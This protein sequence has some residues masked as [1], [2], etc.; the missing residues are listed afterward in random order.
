MKKLLLLL[1]AIVPLVAQTSDSN[2]RSLS[3]VTFAN[4]GTPANGTIVYCSD[5]TAA[6]PVAGSGTGVMARRENGVWNGGAANA[7]SGA[8][9]LVESHTASTS[10]ELDFTTCISGTYDTY[11]IE[12]LN[13]LAVT[14]AANITLQASTNGGASYDTGTNYSTDELIWRFNGATEV[15][16]TGLTAILIN[17]TNGTQNN[18]STWGVAGYMELFNPGSTTVFKEFVGQVGWLDATGRIAASFRSAYESA[19]A[20]NAFR[21]IAS[22]GNLASGTVRCYGLTH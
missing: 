21:I 1:A 17:G 19:T 18:T 3:V 14:S 22:S 4:L 16:G 6:N 11:K 20:M 2:P 10:A 7:G 13:V 12:F 9:V 15:G 8:L 5:C